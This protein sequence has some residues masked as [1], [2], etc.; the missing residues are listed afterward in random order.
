MNHRR[1]HR[2][3]INEQAVMFIGVVE[4]VAASNR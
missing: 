2:Q 1:V 4:D 3:S